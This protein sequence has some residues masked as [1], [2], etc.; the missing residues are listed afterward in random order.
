MQLLIKSRLY[1]QTTILNITEWQSIKD[2][3]AI[4]QRRFDIAIEKQHV[5]Y[6]GH[7]LPDHKAILECQIKPGD[8]ITLRTDDERVGTDLVVYGDSAFKEMMTIIKQ[9]REGL[10]SSMVPELAADGTGL[11]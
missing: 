7:E 8:S 4:L 9:V 5:F 10:R 6:A 2:I 11:T 1:G 3:K